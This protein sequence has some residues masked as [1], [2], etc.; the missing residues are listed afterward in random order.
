MSD[1]FDNITEFPSPEAKS[2][3]EK[4]IGLDEAKD[5]LT[6][7]A[8]LIFNPLI[9]EEWSK[10]HYKR[11]IKLIDQF[12]ARAPLFIFA[13]DVGTG[14][15]SL[16]ESFGD[17]VA[18]EEKI[19]VTLYCLSLKTRGKGLVGEMTKLISDAFESIVK[20]ARKFCRPGKKPSSA[21]ILLID[22]ADALAQSRELEQMN[23]EDKAGVNALIRGIDTV[24]A[25]NLPV[26]VVLC[27]N[28]LNSI[29]PAVQRRAAVVFE[30][31]RPNSEQREFILR[32]ALEDIDFT[33]KQIKAFVEITGES[34]E[35]KYGYTYSDLRQ[36]LLPKIL[37][38][39]LPDKPIH[40]ERAFE[41]ATS[42]KPTPPFK[43]L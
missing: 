42:T 19:S 22:E 28:R 29:D 31:V 1:F 33:D 17:T 8:R 7:E 6:K 12:K 10:K 20:D 24:T 39:A 35:R 37:L 21:I 36:R 25:N 3:F 11:K 16:A 27:T 34:E 2:R 40:Y 14:K 23:H 30:F 4:L 13:G 9:L 43:D 32:E 41:I 26:I 5:H 15:T 18:R 38:D